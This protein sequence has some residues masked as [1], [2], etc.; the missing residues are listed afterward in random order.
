MKKK[1]NIKTQFFLSHMMIAL[2]STVVVLIFFYLYIS[3]ILI[4]RE[5]ASLAMMCNNFQSQTDAK[6]GTLDEVSLNICYNNLLFS[7][8][9][10]YFERDLHNS[11]DFSELDRKSVV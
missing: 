6:L 9:N 7:K 3:S 8:T 5:T 11:D 1:L 2:I 4:E 10:P